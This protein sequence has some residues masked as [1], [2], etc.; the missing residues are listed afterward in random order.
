MDTYF[1]QVTPN[2]DYSL[3][4]VFENGS[5]MGYPMMHLLKQLRFSPLR[6]RDV[7][8]KLDVFSTHLEWNQGAYQVTLNIEEIISDDAG[9]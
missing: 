7:W 1:K 6:D 3:S 8:M 2:Q 5:E 4:I 9:R